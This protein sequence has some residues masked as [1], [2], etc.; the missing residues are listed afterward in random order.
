MK[1]NR[2]LKRRPKPQPKFVVCIHNKDCE[3]L[4]VRKIYRVLPDR[5]ASEDDLL[6]IIDESGEDYLY[7]AAYFVAIELPSEIEKALLLAS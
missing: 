1:T 2:D 4:E 5:S 3:D 6:R 7:P